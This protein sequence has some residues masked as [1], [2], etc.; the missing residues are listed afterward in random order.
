MP[1]LQILL[2][3]NGQCRHQSEQTFNR[4][5]NRCPS[6][7][8]NT[9]T[10]NYWLI[11]AAATVIWPY[12]VGYYFQSLG[13]SKSSS[14]I[15]CPVDRDDR[16]CVMPKHRWYYLCNYRPCLI[17]FITPRVFVL[18][19]QNRTDGYVSRLQ[20]VTINKCATRD[21]AFRPNR[22]QRFCF[23]SHFNNAQLFTS[24]CFTSKLLYKNMKENLL[25]KKK[26][27]YN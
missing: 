2:A 14:P 13:S 18:D 7:R 22:F 4:A 20:A 15:P 25:F 24:L 8:W 5:C 17:D 11:C 26:L 3:L 19:H 10:G 12:H 16:D 27:L 6:L 23:A 9:V 1:P 21:A